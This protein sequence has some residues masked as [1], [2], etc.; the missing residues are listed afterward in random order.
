VDADL[1]SDGSRRLNT[2]GDVNDDDRFY[3]GFHCE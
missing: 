1:G 3:A 2:G